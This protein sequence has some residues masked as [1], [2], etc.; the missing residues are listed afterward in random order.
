MKIAW[1]LNNTANIRKKSGGLC[2]FAGM[3]ISPKY[4]LGIALSGGG[5]RG[6]A[7]VGALKAIEESGLKPDIIAGVSAGSVVATLYAAGVP[8]DRMTEIFHDKGISDFVTLSLTNGGLMKIDK[9]KRLI[10]QTINEYGDFKDL[11]DLPIPTYVGATDI[12]NGLAVEFHSGPI[13][14]RVAASCSI[15][16]VFHPVK[17]DGINYVD[18]G[19][20]HNHPA[21]IIRDKC[22]RL[23][24]INVSPMYTGKIKSMVDVALRTYNLMAKYNQREDMAM[25]DLSVQTPELARYKVFNLKNINAVVMSGYIHTRKALKDAGWWKQ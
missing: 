15:P 20:L 18:G 21:W 24:G 19:V 11:E 8:L 16:I 17:I 10:V 4:E 6:F 9:F 3:Q 25:C 2:N 1:A 5:A 23:I 7:H 12:D 14:E 22:R 13:G